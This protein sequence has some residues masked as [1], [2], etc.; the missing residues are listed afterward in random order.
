MQAGEVPEMFASREV[1][2]RKVLSYWD[3]YSHPNGRF[4][5]ERG[6]E[7]LITAFEG[8]M[9][10]HT[11]GIPEGHDDL[12][13]HAILGECWY[14]AVMA[15]AHK[16]ASM[17][18]TK[19]AC[20]ATRAHMPGMHLSAPSRWRIHTREHVCSEPTVPSLPV[21]RQGGGTADGSRH[22]CYLPMGGAH[23]G[24]VLQDSGVAGGE[25]PPYAS[26]TKRPYHCSSEA[27]DRVVRPSHLN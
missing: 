4:G 26:P 10:A 17:N 27:D 9:E 18:P 20:S 23:V 2:T 25:P 16:V 6:Y 8:L 7:R 12:R 11:R 13:V 21:G 5:G 3:R 22:C 1:L 14:A 24:L 19:N 15:T